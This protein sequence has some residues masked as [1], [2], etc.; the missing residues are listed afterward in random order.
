MGGKYYPPPQVAA[1]FAVLPRLRCANGVSPAS[2]FGSRKR[3]TPKTAV[4]LKILVLV[5]VDLRHVVLVLTAGGVTSGGARATFSSPDENARADET[6]PKFQRQPILGTPLVGQFFLAIRI[7]V[8]WIVF[9]RLFIKCWNYFT[10]AH[11]T[12]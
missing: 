3:K 8:N 9:G 11:P 6:A 2:G 5:E 7:V 4:A 1:R 12:N 10:D